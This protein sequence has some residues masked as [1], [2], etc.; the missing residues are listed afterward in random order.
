MKVSIITVNY[1]QP[2]VTCALLRSIREQDYQDVE[3]IV[4]DNGSRENPEQA[5]RQAYP[6]VLF[7][8][9][10]QNLGFA[11]GNNLACKQAKG[12]YLFFVNNDA[13]I[14]NGCI[15]ALVSVFLTHPQAGLVSPLICYFPEPQWTK[16]MI[17]YAGMS[18]VHPLTGRNQ[19]IGNRSWDEGQYT[20]VRETAYAH[21]AAM[22]T[23]RQVLSSLGPM[24]DSFFLY[25]EELDWG[26]R[27]RK[28]GYTIW[29]S[30]A[31]RVLHKESYTIGPESTI[32]TY[33][34]NRN[35]IWFMR[36]HYKG[37]RLAAF[38]AFL[39]LATIPK[40]TLQYLLSGK[41]DLLQAFWKAVWD[42]CFQG[43]FKNRKQ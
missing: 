15:Q 40:N 2:D 10:E 36:R 23:T 11:G 22:M 32:K 38:Y 1:N 12:E 43:V 7:I 16:S 39:G 18:R 9:S 14:A 24:D 34:L 6:D 4:V 41:K 37:W 28:A 33:Y 26:E 5:I 35:R 25:Y 8:R 13:E 17:Q 29:I 20:G 19:T 21:G 42:G 3:V 27:I 31:A 30:A